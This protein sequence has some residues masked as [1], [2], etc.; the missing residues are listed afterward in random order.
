[1]KVSAPGYLP[2]TTHLFVKDGPY[3]DSDAVFGVR[4]SL[5]VPFERHEPGVAPDGRRMD[6]PYYS[7]HYDFRLLAD[8][9]AQAQGSARQRA[10][11]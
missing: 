5:I 8:A 9:A 3:L 10:S 7:V 1:M 2:V 4:D 6:Q 11:A